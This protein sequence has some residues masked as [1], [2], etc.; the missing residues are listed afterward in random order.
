[1][2]FFFVLKIFE[3]KLSN[4]CENFSL[5][6]GFVGYLVDADAST[7]AHHFIFDCVGSDCDDWAGPLGFYTADDTLFLHGLGKAHFCRPHA[8]SHSIS[9]HFR[10]LNVREHKVKLVGAACR[11]VLILESA[12]RFGSFAAE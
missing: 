4:D 12:N 3:V 10:H 1:L 9:I 11:F 7:F 6:H 2:D 8:L 5:G